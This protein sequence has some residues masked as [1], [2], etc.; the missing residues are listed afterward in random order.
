MDNP[1]LMKAKQAKA[2]AQREVERQKKL[3]N[4]RAAMQQLKSSDFEKARKNDA[5]GGRDMKEHAA[6]KVYVMDKAM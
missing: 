2:E 3:Q 6:K 5:I 1:R 4:K